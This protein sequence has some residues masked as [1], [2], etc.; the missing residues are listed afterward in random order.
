VET[1]R[2]KAQIKTILPHYQAFNKDEMRSEAST[3]INTKEEK[4]QK[5]PQIQI[6]KTN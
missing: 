4:N 6:L 2:S 1:H 3:N 5:K